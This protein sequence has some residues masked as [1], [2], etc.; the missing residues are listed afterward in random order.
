M[1]LHLHMFWP[2]QLCMYVY[3]F[4]LDDEIYNTALRRGIIGGSIMFI[5]HCERWLY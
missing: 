5:M 3:L 4:Q 2:T 1:L